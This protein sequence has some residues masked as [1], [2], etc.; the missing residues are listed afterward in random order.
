MVCQEAGDVS[1]EVARDTKAVEGIQCGPL[2]DVFECSPDVKQRE[3]YDLVVTSRIVQGLYDDGDG[4]S[5]AAMAAES[6]LLFRE[7]L[8][9]LSNPEGTF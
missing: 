5:G 8:H 3:A 4:V 6:A 1:S 2:E 7:V 9:L